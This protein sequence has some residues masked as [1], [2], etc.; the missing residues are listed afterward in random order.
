MQIAAMDEVEQLFGIAVGDGG[1][2]GVG[3]HNLLWL[4][5][6]AALA[7]RLVSFWGRESPRVALLMVMMV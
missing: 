5:G 2:L 1:Q 7:M 6:F 3:K 4:N